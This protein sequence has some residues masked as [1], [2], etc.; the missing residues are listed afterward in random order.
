MS[1]E[2]HVFPGGFAYFKDLKKERSRGQEQRDIIV[3]R[4]MGQSSP[5]HWLLS[6]DCVHFPG[7]ELTFPL[8]PMSSLSCRIYRCAGL[9]TSASSGKTVT[10]LLHPK[11]WVYRLSKTYQTPLSK[12]Q[13]SNTPKI[14]IPGERFSPQC[15]FLSTTA[16]SHP[17]E[18]HMPFC[19]KLCLLSSV[20]VLNPLDWGYKDWKPKEARENP[21][22]NCVGGNEEGWATQPTA[23]TTLLHWPLV[24]H[25]ESGCFSA[26]LSLSKTEDPILLFFILGE[27]EA[28]RQFLPKHTQ[29]VG[30]QGQKRRSKALKSFHRL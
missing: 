5:Y 26:C 2:D 28:C 16:Q 23:A 4:G 1:Q 9:V 20:S 10:K 11:A 24:P 27:T 15:F 29:L 21:D 17:F 19:N 13:D 6:C 30:W 3:S 14:V 7:T 12:K 22:T 25:Q 18:Y 8:D